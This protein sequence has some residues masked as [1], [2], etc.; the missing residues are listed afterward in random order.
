MALE[1]LTAGIAVP[2]Y[3]LGILVLISLGVTFIFA[4]FF[5][6]IKKYAPEAIIMKEARKKHLPVLMIHDASGR[7]E[8]A[9]GR[10]KK[11]GDI[12]YNADAYGIYIDQRIQ[13]SPPEDRTK[14]GV[15]FYHYATNFSF[16]ISGKNARALT[17]I[18]HYVRTNF[19]QLSQINDLEIIE[20]LGT[21]ADELVHDCQNICKEYDLK[22]ED[23]SVDAEF[24]FDATAAKTEK[25]KDRLILYAMANE[26]ARL[27]HR[28]QDETS[29]LPAK[30]E[31]FSYTHA[32]KLIPSAFLS[33]DVHQLKVLLERMVR[34]EQGAQMQQLLAWGTFILMLLVGAGVLYKMVSG[35]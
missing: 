35:S 18:I 17:T 25:E 19:P 23:F 32:F 31:Y 9:L 10:K 4:Y 12:T 29:T 21:D 16:P 15:P 11:K 20:L 13:G 3:I 26:M 24:M 1:F 33:Q 6:D 2:M 28:I 27:I 14:D 22:T 8:L 7:F 30:T 5:S 34:K